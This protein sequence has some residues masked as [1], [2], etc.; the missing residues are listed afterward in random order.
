MTAAVKTPY[1]P[2][3]LKAAS[4][5]VR[6]LQLTFSEISDSDAISSAS[7]M[8]DAADAPLKS[9][10]QLNLDWSKFANHTFFM[11]AEAKVNLAFDQVINGYPFD[12]TRAEVESFLGKLSGFER[13]VF[14]NFPRYRGQL[15]F[16]G[17]TASETT[18]TG[19]SYIIV[20]DHAG[21]LYP[22]LAKS[23]TGGSVLN[24]RG[25]SLTVETH[26]YLPASATVGNQI[27]CQKVSGS[28]HG[29]TLYLTPTTSTTL[30]S[31]VFNVSSGSASL[32]STLTL[33][34]GEFNH[35]CFVLDRD[36]GVHKLN[37]YLSSELQTTSFGSSNIGDMD[38]DASDLIIGSG[39]AFLSNGSTVTPTQTLSGTLDEFRIFH[40][41]RTVAQQRAYASKPLYASPEL[42]LYYRFNEPSAPLATSDDDSVNAI[43][44]DSSGNAL[45]S[46]ISNFFSHVIYDSSGN[47]TGSLLRQD[48]SAD[49]TSKFIHERDERVPV[50][51]PAHPDVVLFNV[52]L[53]NSASVFDRANPNLITRLIPQHYLLEGA[54]FDG[55]EEPE[56]LANS[57]YAG[58]GIPG[59]GQM[60]SVQLL[61]S[62]LYV[63]ALFFDE[64]K[65]HIDAF[66]TL[67]T[68]DYD[69][70][71]SVPNN[72]LRSLVK[73]YGLNLLPLFNDASIDQYVRAENIDEGDSSSDQSLRQVQNELLRRV[74]INLPDIIR[75]KG[76]QHSIKSFL[77]AVGIDPDNSV[78]LRE[79][80]GPTSRRLS[81]SRESKRN[82]DAMVEFTT[83]SYARSMYL[84]ASRVEPGT[85]VAVGPFVN[86]ALFSPAGISSN[87]SDGLLTSGSWS[88][89]TTVKY[90]D[91]NIS[92]MTSAT[93]SLVRF[94]TS[95]SALTGVNYKGLIAN[96]L[97]VSSSLE[98]KLIFYFRP[99][100]NNGAANLLFMTMSLPNNAFFDGEPWSVSFGCNRNDTPGGSLVS[101]YFLRTAATNAGEIRYY[102]AT[103]SLFAEANGT[104]PGVNTVTRLISDDYNKY[105][106][107]IEVGQNCSHG[108]DDY[109]LNDFN[110]GIPDD[111]RA[112]DFTG[113]MSGLRFWSKALT[114]SEWK[115]HVRN[116]RSTGV[117]DPT[118]NWSYA[119]A[120]SG[121]FERLRMNVFN[122]QDTRTANSAGE[123][124]FL[125][126]SEN[127][128][129]MTGSGFPTDAACVVSEVFETSHLSP[130]YDE[131]VTNEKVRIRG[132][133]NQ[134]DVDDTPWAQVAPAYE[135]V[136]SERP[137]DD[138]RFSVDMSLIDALNRDIISMFATFDSLDNAL[139][140]PELAF[141]PDYPGLETLRD[142]YFNRIK[143]RLNF[144]AFFEFF[145]WF[146]SSIGTFI[147]Q[148]LPRKTSFRGTNYVIE[149]HMLERHKVQYGVNQS[150]L[151]EGHRL[152]SSDMIVQN[153]E[154]NLRKY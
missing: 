69:Q 24:P 53:L 102:A 65:Q 39:S 63:W 73:Q 79:Y 90:N 49:P 88:V 6:P 117:S 33:R 131:A 77:R 34:K 116:N 11:S 128:M 30:G 31:A 147:S 134:S 142:I 45:H 54:L 47:L 124:V 119:R 118:L 61:L 82:I 9:T 64:I 152:N 15:M 78:R 86:H 122:K 40:S 50:L 21:S 96:L 41:A 28:T 29:F 19:G 43:V 99:G 132:F 133:L 93:Q 5:G 59:Q 55:Y 150:Y 138:V 109:F 111:A 114:E 137:D 46:T 70:N 123:I 94:C 144:K 71:V 130:Y 87:L 4:D 44:L 85:P 22:E 3:F 125:D 148:L 83:S 139:G 120:R 112:V 26:L 145:R 140:A 92:S 32:T 2:S 10:Q 51:F 14:D 17:S 115:E 146:D 23:A 35:L 100:E 127:N 153:I 136:A 154:G 58:S 108:H 38:I 80:G 110:D 151:D 37:G 105:G 106:L 48:A 98:P 81:N 27:I 8:Y 60:G 91:V 121:S 1:V 66:S 129:H 68:V 67:R 76:T 56:G 95:G 107:F 75:S 89:E 52:E 13:W 36:S 149:S 57:A 104:S 113:R 25:T 97:V 101:S 42:K 126:M 84:S 20:K 74:L 103:S 16:T 62:M 18:T 72:F 141:S 143:E 12:G 135:I 7:F